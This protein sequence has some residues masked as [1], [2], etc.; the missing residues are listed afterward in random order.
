MECGETRCNNG[1]SQAGLSCD[2]KDFVRS[3][4]LLATHHS[5]EPATAL[6]AERNAQ[7]EDVEDE[8]EEG[9]KAAGEQDVSTKIHTHEQAL[10]CISELM[11][12]ATDSNSSSFKL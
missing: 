7:N 11:Q 1:I 2:T 3:D 6:L 12:F 8:E 5:S 4:D 9:E 10:Y